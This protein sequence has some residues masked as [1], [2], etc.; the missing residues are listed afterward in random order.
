M[1]KDQSGMN[2]KGQ[3][4]LVKRTLFTAMTSEFWEEKWP[5]FQYFVNT[6]NDQVN[7]K[8]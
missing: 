7:L 2:R 4:G 8:K 3:S 6:C 1:I 5:W